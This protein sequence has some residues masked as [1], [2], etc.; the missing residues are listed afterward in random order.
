LAIADWIAD[1][2]I[3]DLDWRLVIVEWILLIIAGT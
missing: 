3:A 1:L 2:A